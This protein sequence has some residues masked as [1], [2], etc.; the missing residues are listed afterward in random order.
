MYHSGYF[1]SVNPAGIY[2]ALPFFS[3]FDFDGPYI[4]EERFFLDLGHLTLQL[5]DRDHVLLSIAD[6][7]SKAA[8]AE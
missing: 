4:C 1:L 6:A 3:A 8:A 2:V 5:N 7:H